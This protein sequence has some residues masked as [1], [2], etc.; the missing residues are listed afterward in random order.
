MGSWRTDLLHHDIVRAEDRGPWQCRC[1]WHLNIRVLSHRHHTVPTAH[2]VARARSTHYTGYESIVL[3]A[4]YALLW[5]FSLL[6]VGLW[7]ERALRR[8]AE[9]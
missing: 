4:T 3:Y 6:A 2:V 7:A 1:A 5:N 9:Q 8:R